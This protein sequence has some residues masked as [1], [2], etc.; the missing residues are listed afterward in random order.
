ME[1]I[2]PMFQSSSIEIS[3]V[4]PTAS[5]HR[6]FLLLEKK[7]H[8]SDIQN[9]HR[10]LSR[11]VPEQCIKQII[12]IKITMNKPETVKMEIRTHKE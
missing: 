12:I 3:A 11:C 4:H 7:N 8:L 9:V 2:E 6:V 1:G 10:N 5:L